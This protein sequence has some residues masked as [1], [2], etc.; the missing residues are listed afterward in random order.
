MDFAKVK[1]NL[2]KE[3][4]GDIMAA[5]VAA[6]KY[7]LKDGDKFLETSV[8]QM[9]RRIA[10]VI[11]ANSRGYES[12]IESEEQIFELLHRR[13]IIFGGR[14]NAGLGSKEL[15]SLSNCFVIDGPEDSYEDI[16]RADCEQ[17]QLMKRGGGVGF[18]LSKLREYGSPVNNAAKTSTGPVSFMPRYSNTTLEV[19]QEGRRGALMLAIDAYHK[20]AGKFSSSKRNKNVINGANIS[21][22]V[23]DRFMK[24]AGV[25]GTYEDNLLNEVAEAMWESA[26][27]GVL[28]WDNV[29]NNPRTAI[30]N[31]VVATNPCG[32]LPL[33][34]YDSCRLV[35]VNHYA[36]G[37]F[38]TDIA[39]EEKLY[40]I[41]YLTTVLNDIIIN[42]EIDR[43]SNIIK[44]TP[45]KSIERNLWTKIKENAL[46]Y[47]NSGVGVTGTADYLAF[48]NLLYTD[49]EEHRKLAQIH[50]KATYEASIDMAMSLDMFPALEGMVEDMAPFVKPFVSEEYY[51]KYLRY[52]KRNV[53]NTT[54]APV[55]SGAIMLQTT[56]GIEPI[57]EPILKR[58]R[59]GHA[60]EPEWVEYIVVHRPL[61]KLLDEQQIL[62]DVND[63]KSLRE[64]YALTSYQSARS[65]DPI[66]KIQVQA[67]WQQYIDNSISI[68]Y[69]LPAS[70]T[71]Q[72]IRT[73]IER[74]WVAGLKGFTV[75]REG[76]RDAI[77][78]STTE[79]T[80]TNKLVTR[81]VELP[82]E[83]HSVKIE[84]TNWTVIIGL[85][86]GKPY[87]IFALK[88][89]MVRIKDGLKGSLIK[90][91]LGQTTWYDFKS[92]CVDIFDLISHYQTGNE[93]VLTKLVSR[94]LR[95]GTKISSI[96]ND[97]LK[98]NA[99]IGTFE[100]VL[101][102][103]LSKYNIDETT[104]EYVRCVSC[105]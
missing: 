76:S 67:V 95:S 83:V 13:F 61:L 33:S 71:P 22:Q 19:A 3:F 63:E 105:Q 87:E 75:Y 25:E 60:G 57:F 97:F 5:E 20:D 88:E 15:T 103:V 9:N 11:Y 79:D 31:V 10:S 17:V 55:G 92:D 30:G 28:F 98:V 4:D 94:A 64:A 91:N 43:I 70:T 85:L 54:I 99:V 16:L 78:K 52:G 49:L 34:P 18:T 37:R 36:I 100:N 24:Q 46:A 6:H 58:K 81:P 102:R 14:V 56:S 47:R 82:C 41:T 27:P 39:F 65:I 59:R 96:C 2:I 21:L 72:E 77:L 90:N 69:N 48:K 38:Y 23:S 80:D 53:T 74:A 93:Q 8:E 32:E 40:E 84:A 62:Y 51:D 68:T 73:Y 89:Q 86:E 26:E 12:F 45:R 66:E 44:A 101:L 7:L 50:R 42:I 104:G 29:L 1:E 35:H